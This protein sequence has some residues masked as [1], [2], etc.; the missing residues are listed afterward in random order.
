[1]GEIEGIFAKEICLYL[2]EWETDSVQLEDFMLIFINEIFDCIPDK[3]DKAHTLAARTIVR[4]FESLYDNDNSV[5]EE[6]HEYHK[7]N[8]AG[9]Q[10]VNNINPEDVE[11]NINDDCPALQVIREK[12]DSSTASAPGPK[13]DDFSDSEDDK[14]KKK[15][16]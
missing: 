16:K 3:S 12:N 2:L 5:Y 15:K 4:L 9:I 10:F 6:I 1:M 11:S 7:K 14:P 13:D 8:S